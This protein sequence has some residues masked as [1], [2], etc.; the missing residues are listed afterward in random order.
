MDVPSAVWSFRPIIFN[1]VLAILVISYWFSPI[2]VVPVDDIVEV[3]FNG[4]L[5]TNAKLSNGKR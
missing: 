3:D 2:S 1:A 5:S 4:P